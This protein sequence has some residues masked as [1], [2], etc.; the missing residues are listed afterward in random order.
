MNI[1][2]TRRKTH[3]RSCKVDSEIEWAKQEKKPQDDSIDKETR[4]KHPRSSCKV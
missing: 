2:K 3:P 4:Q 1:L